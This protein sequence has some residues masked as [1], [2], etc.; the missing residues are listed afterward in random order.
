MRANL[1][2]ILNDQAAPFISCL[3]GCDPEEAWYQPLTFQTFTDY[4]PKSNPDPLAR[5]LF[6]CLEDLAE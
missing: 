4:S 1:T 5:I 3:T 2:E 6:G